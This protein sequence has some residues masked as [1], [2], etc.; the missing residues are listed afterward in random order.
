[1]RAQTSPDVDTNTT[2]TAFVSHDNGSHWAALGPQGEQERTGEG[3]VILAPSVAQTAPSASK[4][5]RCRY[6]AVIL[7]FILRAWYGES[8]AWYG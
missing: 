8:Q 6:S 3:S 5:L 7:R 4:P 2:D 1:M